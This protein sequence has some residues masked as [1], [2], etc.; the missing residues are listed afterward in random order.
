MTSKLQLFMMGAAASTI[1]A[2]TFAI[3]AADARPSTRS[4][5][6]SGA[7]NLVKSRGKIVMNHKSSSL[8]RLF[9]ANRSY[10]ARD[11]TTKIFVVPTKSGSC[12]L[13]IC[14]Q[15]DLEFNFR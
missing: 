2:S 4:Y 3:S 7:K 10:C 5:T 1:I 6:C 12:R 9:V 14:S 15:L 13:K 11:E 8:Y